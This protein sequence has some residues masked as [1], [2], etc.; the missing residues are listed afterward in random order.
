M[1]PIIPAPWTAGGQIQTFPVRTPSQAYL[2]RTVGGNEGGNGTNIATLID[3]LV[4]DGVW[5]KLDAL[6]VLAQQNAT[7]SLLNLV[8]TSYSP[9]IWSG[10]PVFTSYKGYVFSGGVFNTNFTPSSATSPNYALNSAS[11]GFWAYSAITENVHQIGTSSAVSGLYGDFSG[12]TIS[13]INNTTQ[14]ITATSGALGLYAADRSS[15]SNVNNYYNGGSQGSASVASS[16]LESGVFLLGGSTTMPISA[17][18][19]GASLGS[20]GQLA[21]YTRLR[22]YMTAV[23]VP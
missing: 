11:F 12:S 20:A 6:Y 15:S 8:G 17:A 1:G 22:T 18:F 9:T 4:A 16:A 2:A 19:F 7:D 21:L 5:A 13:Q 10:S 3:G 23:G 14:C